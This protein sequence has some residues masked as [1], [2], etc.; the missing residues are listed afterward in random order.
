MSIAIR[1][2]LL[3]VLLG[4]MPQRVIA[5]DAVIVPPDTAAFLSIDIMKE[6][7]ARFSGPRGR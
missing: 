5:D 6:P 1:C 2:L 3:A 4:L 7:A